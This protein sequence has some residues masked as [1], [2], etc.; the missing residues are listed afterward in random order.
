MAKV[1]VAMSGGVDSSVAAALL[2]GAGCEVIG[3]FMKFWAP[4][5]GATWINAD[6]NADLRGFEN[7]CC[8]PEAEIRARKVAKILKIPFYV[9]NFEKG[10]LYCCWS[11]YE[12]LGAAERRHAD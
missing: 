12:V 5:S 3:V 9:F 10:W 1:V 8:S 7:R 4:P 2:K 6:S 11:F